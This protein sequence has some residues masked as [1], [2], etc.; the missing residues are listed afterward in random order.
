MSSSA[1]SISW[2]DNSN[3]ETAFKVERAS[4]AGGPWTQIG[5]TTQAGYGDSSLP[6]STTYWYRVRATNSSGDSPYSNTGSAATMASVGGAHVWSTHFGGPTAGSDAAK[7]VG[8]V[9]DGTGASIVLGTMSGSVNFGGGTLTSAGGDDVY[10]VKYS[11]TGAFVWAQRFG[12]TQSE[13][14][15]GIAVDPSG[16]VVITGF[17]RGSASFGGTALV[18]TSASGF[19]AKYS[20][21]GAHIWSK[22]LTTGTGLDE[23]TAVATDRG[24][25]VIVGA[26]FYNTTDFGRGPMTAAG[27]EDIALLKYDAN[28]NILWSKQVSGAADEVVTG[29]ATDPVTDEFV[30]VGYFAGTVNFGGTQKISAGF[31]DA[32]VARYNSAGTLSWVTAWGSTSD[33]KANGVDVDNLGNVA[34]TGTFTN[35]VDFGGGPITNTGGT[36][37]ADIFLVKLSSAGIHQW[38]RG[39]GSAGVGQIGHGVAFDGAGNVLLTGSLVALTSPYTVD[40]GGG[41]ISGNG[42]YN[43]FIAKYSGSGAE[44]WAKSYIAGSADA[45]GWSIG[46]DANNNVIAA[47]YY[48]GSI[49][50]GGTTM[51]SPGSEDTYLVKLAP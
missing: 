23:G 45:F 1:I 48:Q 50:F 21:T 17:F 22:R 28:G 31:N 44:I 51:M 43:P 8:M 40:L 4:A 6:P 36:S 2:T 10:L 14:P 35:N 25:N 18:G 29:I 32:F 19:L 33:D 27:S 3:N 24:G 49:N 26:G 30:A 12:G 41:P 11:S 46:A 38:S 39:F 34:V 47:G 15:K 5:L 42:Y 37:S 20:P 9:V 13:V 16:N 7:S